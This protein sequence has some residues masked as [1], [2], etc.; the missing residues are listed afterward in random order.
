MNLLTPIVLASI[1]C[2]SAVAQDAKMR[3]AAAKLSPVMKQAEAML[4]EGKLTEANALVLNTFPQETRTPAQSLILGNVLYGPDPKLSYELHKAAAAGLPNSP[5]ALFE[6]AM[7]QHR[8]KEY[9]AAAKTYDAY[10]KLKPDH[11]RPRSCRRVQAP[12]RRY[13]R[14]H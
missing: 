11:A 14:R 2:T 1:L 5:E 12:Q 3:E 4:V 7:E 9:A 6:W 13:R 8:A 10:L